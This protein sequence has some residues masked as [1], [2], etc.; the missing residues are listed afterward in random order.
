MKYASFSPPPGKFNHYHSHQNFFSTSAKF[1][2]LGLRISWTQK[3][4]SR[5]LNKSRIGKHK[6]FT[7]Y[8]HNYELNTK[9]ERKNGVAKC[10]E[11]I[12][13]TTGYVKR[14]PLDHFLLLSLVWF[15]FLLWILSLCI[16]Y[17]PHP[18]P[19]SANFCR[20]DQTANCSAAIHRPY[21]RMG[22]FFSRSIFMFRQGRER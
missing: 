19:T 13:N 21:L 5:R 20:T 1:S 10:M 9:N 8:E 17:G 16:K 4:N 11:Q 3:M 22:V 18:V 6:T 2:T 12:S 15:V 7:N 14:A